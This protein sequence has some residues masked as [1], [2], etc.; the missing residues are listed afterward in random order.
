MKLS[1]KS[2]AWLLVL[3]LSL[4]IPL[5][6]VVAQAVYPEVIPLFDG[7]QP[8]G[9]AVGYGHTFY[10]GS[11]NGG[12]VF[13][14][15]LR[16]GEV[17][18]IAAPGARMSVGMS[19]DERSG[20]LFV[21]G[22]G[23]GAAYVFDGKT[24]EM[25]ASYQLTSPPTFVNDVIV[26][27][28]A[29]YFTDSFQ[30]QLYVLPL[31]PGGSLPDPA[32]VETLP[33]GDGFAFTPGAFNANG[34]EASQDG[35]TLIVVNSSAASLFT[36]DPDTGEATAID[37]GGDAVPNGDGLLLRGRTLYVVQNFLNQVA[38][39]DLSPDFSEGEITGYL[40]SPHFRVPTT[41]AIFGDALYLV[42]ARFDEI[43]GGQASPTDTF[44]AVR[45]P[46]E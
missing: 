34:I 2:L 17:E 45:V 4:L 46:I 28:Q 1:F 40:T 38:V 6:A 7:Y 13:R 25:V 21:A 12:A 44:E 37:L 29:A 22:G 16:S 26:T 8:E 39:V 14:G 31:G 18:M 20:L 23:T 41:A 36:V 24:G 32:D 11:L 5:S 3:T 43:P 42:N 19:F 35:S 27:R 30:K 15:D 9:I 33:L 10:T